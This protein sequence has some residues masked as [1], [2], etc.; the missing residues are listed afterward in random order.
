MPRAFV[1]WATHQLK[2]EH[3]HSEV[4]KD[5]TFYPCCFR[6]QRDDFKSSSC[7]LK[8][9][10]QAKREICCSDCFPVVFVTLCARNAAWTHTQHIVPL[11]DV[12]RTVQKQFLT[13]C[14]NDD[15]FTGCHY[16]F[17]SRGILRS[18]TAGFHLARCFKFRPLK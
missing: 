9:S 15:T 18:L 1:L 16:K 2:W 10:F 4:L 7:S 12:S 11:P 3:S 14:Y 8:T 17:S 6:C 13:G 5:W